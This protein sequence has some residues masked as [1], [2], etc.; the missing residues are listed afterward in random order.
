M[1]KIVLKNFRKFEKNEFIFDKHLTLIS[2]KSGK[3]KTTIFMAIIFA[4]TSEGKKLITYGK[5]SCSVTLEMTISNNQKNTDQTICITRSKRPNRLSVDLRPTELDNKKQTTYEDKEAQTIIDD[6]FPQYYLGYMSQR[7]DN[8][9]F[10][11]MN[12]VDKMRFIQKI[13]FGNENVDV[14]HKNCRDLI[15]LR[16]DDMMLT[17]RE[18]ETTEKMLDELHIKKTTSRPEELQKHP[19]SLLSIANEEE[20]NLLAKIK[21]LEKNIEQKKRL[22]DKTISLIKFKDDLK[23]QLDKIPKIDDD[24]CQIEEQIKHIHLQT[25]LWDNYQKEKKKLDKLKKP[26]DFQKEDIKIMISDMKQ[27]IELQ[28]QMKIMDDLKKKLE[29]FEKQIQDVSIPMQCPEC[30]KK[31][32][33]WCDKNG[34]ATLKSCVQNS[35]DLICKVVSTTYEEAKNIEQNKYKLQLQ[36]QEFEKKQK[37]LLTLKEDYLDLDDP[38]YQLDML[39]QIWKNDEDYEKQKNICDS[40]K[41]KEQTGMTFSVSLLNELKQKQ[42]NIYTRNEKELNYNSIKINDN[43]DN[44]K[45]KII[46]LNT[47]LTLTKDQQKNLQSLKYW[48]KV[49][50]LLKHENILNKSYPRAVK[51]QNIIKQAEKLAI[52]ETIE[53]INLHVQLYLDYFL[54]NVTVCLAFDKDGTK[55]NVNVTQN[56]FESDLNNLSGGELARVVLA[57][58][59]ALADMNSVK[60]LML[61]ECVSSLDQ[62]TTTSVIKTIQSNFTGQIICIAH[63]T[64]TGIFDHVLNL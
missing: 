22:L 36:I 7:V 37:H 46:I 26:S 61:D 38:K 18:R 34:N 47:E 44:I 5:N 14:L 1:I 16:K 50:I 17:S 8:K 15:K 24:I 57:F 11:L 39:Y 13:A 32:E 27:M 3:G 64:T 43:I 10:I 23:I 40:F 48:S 52:E 21:E 42:K 20:E 55:L 31:I 63:Q 56:N 49:D 41:I 2:G 29:L 53:Q 62:E 51:L 28:R 30:Q 4:L 59:I 58:T 12:P 9:S 6:L 45:D 54:E 60:L 25:Q 35:K 19:K 33:L